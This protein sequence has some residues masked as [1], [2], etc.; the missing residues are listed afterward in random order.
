[1]FDAEEN[2]PDE[3]VFLVDDGVGLCL[4]FRAQILDG[5]ALEGHWNERG[6]TLNFEVGMLA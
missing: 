4:F 3:S 2:S 6:D 5:D 1:M